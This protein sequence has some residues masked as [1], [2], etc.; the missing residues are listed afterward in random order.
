VKGLNQG[1]RSSAVLFKTEGF[2]TVALKIVVGTPKISSI[3]FET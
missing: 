2:K 3:R 1:S